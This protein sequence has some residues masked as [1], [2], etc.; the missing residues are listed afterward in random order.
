M[1][2]QY[3]KNTTDPMQAGVIS[4]HNMRLEKKRVYLVPKEKPQNIWKELD[5]ETTQHLH[6]NHRNIINQ[7]QS[8]NMGNT[9]N[10]RENM[11]K[12]RFDKKVAGKIGSYHG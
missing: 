4:E 8:T 3:P 1:H 6:E 7:A 2:C 5:P 11:A 9:M 12:Q 10:W